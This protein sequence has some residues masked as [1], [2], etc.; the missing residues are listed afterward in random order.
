MSTLSIEAAGAASPDP[1]LLRPLALCFR[2]VTHRYGTKTA[3]DRLNLDVRQGE[4]LALLGP[5]GAGKSTTISVLLGLIRPQEGAV[6]VL[7]SD[8]SQAVT[9]GRVGAMLQSGSAVGLPPGVR[10][11]QALHLV[12]RLYHRPA[13]LDKVIEQAK[14]R[15]LLHE[16]TDRL[17]GG[18]AQRVRFAIA[19]AG[20]PEVVFLDEPTSAMDVESRQA[21]WRMMREFGDEGRTVVFATHHLAEA[22][23]IADRVVVLNHGRVVA[24]GPG[25]TLKAAVATRR[26][27]FVSDH[28]DRA[29]LSELDGVTEVEVRGTSVSIDSL[30]ADATTRD[31]VTRDVPFRDLEVT[32]AGLEQ[33]FVALTCKPANPSPANPSPANSAPVAGAP[34][35]RAAIEPAAA[36]PQEAPRA[37]EARPPIGAPGAR[38]SL[39]LRRERLAP[40]VAFAGF[41]VGRLLRSW[42]FLAITIGFPV[43]FY[44]LFLGDHTAGAVV[45]G[46]VPWRVYLMVS[47]CSFGALVAALNAGGTR[48][49][50]ERASGWARQLRVTPIPAWSYVGTKIFASML[51]VLPVIALVEVVGAGFGDVRLGAAAWVGLTLLMWASSLPFAVLGVF[52]GFLV[53]TEAAFPVVTGLMFVLG[54]FGGLF[55]PVDRMPGALQV[56]AHLLPSYH[57]DALGLAA[58]DGHTLAFSH[59]AVL[60]GYA[61]VLGLAIAWKH[62]AQEARGIA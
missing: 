21:F 52:I 5:N 44:L 32:C 33:A 24:D 39:G 45:D 4:V 43:I 61:A 30:D 8:P 23:E 28:L 35:S 47:M 13:P 48:L 34:P 42:K 16:R 49:S 27:R 51:V 7:G 53:S 19:I 6:E 55:T 10:V 17:S 37:Q 40:L 11:G 2:S 1:D 14:I 62:R 41:E 25:A 18:Q 29:L 22:D 60:I 31:L 56:V 54:Y 58:L 15:S 20:D 59:W 36:Q 50:M 9:D 38:R 46:A 26:L 57:N 3:L 12:R